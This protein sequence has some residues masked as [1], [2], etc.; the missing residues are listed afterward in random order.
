MSR[1][2]T[3]S[4]LMKWVAQS[5]T[6]HM[7]GERCDAAL[8]RFAL[9]KATLVRTLWLAV[10]AAVLPLPLLAAGRIEGQIVNGTTQKPAAGQE[11]QLLTPG[12]RE[13]H[14]LAVTR[15]SAQGRF[16]FES[17]SIKAGSFYLIQAVHDGVN[18]HDAVRLTTSPNATADLKIYNSTTKA[19]PFHVTSA[20]F[21]IRAQDNKVRVEELYAL[22]NTTNPPL[23]YVDPNGTFRFNLAGDAGQPSVAVAGEMNMPLPQDAQPGNTPGQYSIQYPLK[24]GLTVVMVE[25]EADYSSAAFDL[26]DSVPYPIDQIELDVVPAS[27]VVKSNL[28]KPV[29]SD[30]DTGGQKLAAAKLKPNEIIRAS[31]SGTSLASP[32][33]SSEENTNQETVKELP[34]PITRLGAPLLGCFLLVLLWAM[35]MRVS[36]EWSRRDAARAGSP[37]QKELEAKIEKL[38]DSVANLDELFE[39]GK[40]SEKKYWRERL[41]LKAKIV[42]FLKMSPPAFIESYAT[43]HNL[44]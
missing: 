10:I 35:G 6:H 20:R 12:N 11:V 14:Q 32:A 39:A 5:P 41:D 18:Y 17:D 44:H 43:R 23:A 2:R 7:G 37:A 33:G 30:A 40:I 27:L 28:F 24:P 8:R 19:P 1:R 22:R 25:Y 15:T 26:A 3:A 42:V 9:R 16:A 34:N 29:G 21:L 36:R 4:V 13:I 38:L 31:L